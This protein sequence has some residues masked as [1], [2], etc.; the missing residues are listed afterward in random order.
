MAIRIKRST[1]SSAPATLASG[2]LAYAEGNGNLYIGYTNG[3]VINIGGK[4]DHDK[5]AGIEAGAQ[6]NDVTSVAGRTG[7]VTISTSDLSDFN[8]AADA[9]ISAASIDALSDVV[10]TTPSNG[11]QLS[12]DSA[13]SKWINT[14]PSSGVTAFTQLND[15]PASYSGKALNFVRV[16]TGATALEFTQDIDDGQF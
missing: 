15:A 5:L 10:I 2:Q 9:R 16:N 1:G 4:T 3:D 14:A 11:Q 12:W 7:D 6:V 8:T 13:T